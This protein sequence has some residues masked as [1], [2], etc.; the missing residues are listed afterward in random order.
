MTRRLYEADPGLGDRVFELLERVF[1]GVGRGRANGVA[2]GVPWESVST[3]FVVTD[4]ERVVAHVGLMPLPFFINGRREVV[5]AVHGVA[6]DPDLRGRGLFRSLMAQLLTFA[7]DRFQTL[8]LTTAHP[9]YFRSF[10]FQVVPESIFRVA[11]PPVGGPAGRLLDLGTP[12]DRAVITS[13][14]R[15]RAPLSPVLAAADD[16]G[17]WAFYEFGS[18]I[19]YDAALDVAVIAERREDSLAVFDLVAA[20]PPSLADIVRIAGVKVQEVVFYFDPAAAI[21]GCRVAAH[22]LAGGVWALE[23]GVTN[24]SF[25]VRGQWESAGRSLMLPRPARS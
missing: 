23:P 25:M 4:G 1:P 21:E 13:L 16:L 15:R 20:R 22:D 11:A 3:P 6:T 19:R 5:G 2:F 12:A 14:I 24:L 17:C 10:G 9:E 8:T 18:E 7:A